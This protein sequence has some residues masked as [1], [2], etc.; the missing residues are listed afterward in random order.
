MQ[1]LHQGVIRD[2]EMYRLKRQQ[3]LA[4]ELRPADNGRQ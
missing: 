2:E 4:G 1:K 3:M